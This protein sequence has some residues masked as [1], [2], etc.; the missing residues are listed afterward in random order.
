M[1]MMKRFLRKIS[2]QNADSELKKKKNKINCAVL[3]CRG[4]E[5]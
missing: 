1:K 3:V 2:M 5:M 4:F